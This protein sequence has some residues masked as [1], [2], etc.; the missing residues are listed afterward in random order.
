MI[1]TKLTV[2]IITHNEEDAIQRCLDSVKPVADEIVVVDSLSDDYTAEICRTNGCKVFSREFDGY[3]AQKQFGVDQA[4]NN[5]ILSVDADEVLT[6]ELQEEINRVKTDLIGNTGFKIPFSLS[7]MGKILKHGG[8]GHESHLRLF[9]RNKGRFTQVPVH[10]GV[11]V[12]G[13]IGLLKGK[14]IHY[15]YH[16]LSH[17]LEKI[18]KYSSQAA[19]NFRNKGKSFPKWWVAL[20]FPASFFTIY[21]IK[22]GFLDGYA[23]FL[24]SFLNAIYATAKV[25]KTIEQDQK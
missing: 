14:I 16:D 9:N 18:N 15:S 8:V 11:E 5:W 1:M 21:F 19:Q 4:S 10:E 13:T 2:V 25:A 24:W 17:Q 6:K 22:K 20:K 23:G 12:D 3:G 7:Y